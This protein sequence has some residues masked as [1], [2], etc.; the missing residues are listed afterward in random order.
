MNDKQIAAEQHFCLLQKYMLCVADIISLYKATTMRRL[1]K[2]LLWAAGITLLLYVAVCAFFYNQQD[3]ILFVP[4]RLDEHYK[5]PFPGNFTERKIKANDGTV[6]SGLLFKADSSKGLIF[7]LHGNGG[8]LENWGTAAEVYTALRY[9]VFML[10]YRGYGKSEGKI[11]SEAQL[12]ADVQAAYTD[13]C[14]S[15]AEDKI[16][17]LGYSI[18]TGPAAMLAAHNQ[19]RRLILQAPYYSMVDMMKNTYSFLPVFLL[20]YPLHTDDFVRQTKAQIVIFHGDAD[21]VIY[22]GS[23]LKLRKH[24]KPGDQLITLSGQR[25]NGITFN[26][27]YRKA[28]ADLLK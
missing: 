14:R 24:F 13:L 17:V 5:F 25:H 4:T 20:K 21:E 18:G 10:D 23:S 9:D 16:T 19:P 1:R 28:L 8:S 27:E 26:A 2:I 12:Y 6:L 22:Y 15:Y 7:Y 3:N 11:T